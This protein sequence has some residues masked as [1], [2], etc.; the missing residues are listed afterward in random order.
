MDAYFQ[1]ISLFRRRNYDQCIEVC[2]LLLIQQ[3]KGEH[4]HH[5]GRAWELKIR[6]MT[7]RVY[8]DEIEADDGIAGKKEK[9]N[10]NNDYDFFSWV[11]IFLLCCLFVS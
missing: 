2:N 3:R 1:A 6:A 5:Q 11:C 10:N 8:I 4:T 7:Q 9:K